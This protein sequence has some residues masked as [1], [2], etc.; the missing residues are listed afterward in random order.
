MISRLA[1]RSSDGRTSES[2]CSSSTSATEG[3][4]RRRALPLA[5]LS[6]LLAAGCGLS[7]KR[8]LSLVKPA[9][10][11]FDDMCGLQEYF[12]ALKDTSQTAPTEVFARDITRDET[13]KPL[14]GRK[15]F[16]FDNEFQLKALRKVLSDNWN[17]IPDEVDRAS[18]V[19]LEVSWA[20]KAGVARVVTTEEALLAV[21]PRAGRCPTTCACRIC[22]SGSSCTRPAGRCSGCRRRATGRW[23][24]TA[25]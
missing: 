11:V 16:K 23:R 9:E 17:K 22:C 21:G 5:G 4:T 8:D 19:E 6:L 25:R 20:D 18:I 24:R 7:V 1:S 13:S 14:G 15:R 10:V 3:R 12:D 2:T